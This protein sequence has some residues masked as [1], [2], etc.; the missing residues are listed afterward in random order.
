MSIKSRIL[1][2]LRSGF[3]LHFFKIFIKVDLCRIN[4]CRIN[5]DGELEHIIILRQIKKLIDLFPELKRFYCSSVET[6]F[7]YCKALLDFYNE[8]I[9]LI[10]EPAKET[11]VRRLLFRLQQAVKSS[12]FHDIIENEVAMSNLRSGVPERATRLLS[13]SDV[14]GEHQAVVSRLQRDIDEFEKNYQAKAGL[15]R[16][17]DIWGN[18]PGDVRGKSLV[19]FLKTK[20]NSF[21]GKRI[22]HIAPESELKKFFLNKRVCLQID[23]LTLDAYSNADIRQDITC[24]DLPDNSVDIV[25][26]H[27]VLEHILDDTAAIKEIYRVLRPGGMLNISVPQSVQMQTTNEWVIPDFTHDDHVR[28]YGRDFEQRLQAVGFQV[29]TEYCLLNRTIEEHVADGTY[30]MRI[31]TCIK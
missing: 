23:Y 26:C 31:Y 19:Y 13:T 1:E 15:I 21:E 16:S 5:E 30:P 8:Y 9:P 12:E 7:E 29:A 2:K 14:S 28:Q 18:M 20:L 17:I 6:R 10:Y 22:L 27:R 11:Q 3:K 24:L 25:I 4:E